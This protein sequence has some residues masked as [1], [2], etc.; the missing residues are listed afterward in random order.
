MAKQRRK[1]RIKLKS[2]EQ[3]LHISELGW[4][5]DGVATHDGKRVFVPFTL[6]G[7]TVRAM[8][9]GQR[10]KAIEVLEAAPQR[11]TAECSHFGNCG[12]CAVQ[13]L[14]ADD[15]RLWKRRVIEKAL[16]NR[17][18]DVPVDAL[19]DAHGDGRRRV[20]LHARFDGQRVQVGFMQAHT[21]HLVD[22]DRCPILAPQLE[23]ATA[24]ARDLAQP[25]AGTPKPLDIQ[26]TATETGLD[27]TVRGAGEVDLDIRMA[28][29]DCASTHDLARITVG[30]DIILE[31]RPPQLTFG[32]TKVTMP[33]GGFLQATKLGEETLAALVLDGVGNAKKVAD[34][35]CGIGPF[36]LR[37]AANAQVMAIDSDE[38]AIAA[39]NTAAHHTQG[40]KPITTDV[41]DLTHNP[42]HSSE[43]NKFDAVVFDPPRAGA[44]EQAWEIGQSRVKTV[45]GVSCNPATFAHDAS[46][47]LD[48]GYTLEKVTP[49]DQFRYAGHIEMV[50]IFRR[51]G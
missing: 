47:L 29:S 31:R 16:T 10:A 14:S 3:I 37:M 21:H 44:E 27:C 26:M 33:S 23:N 51:Q 17:D 18:M 45:V 34:L 19:I 1:K 49:V 20:T 42:M 41:R 11:V 4:H 43:L 24:I 15:Y 25:F 28:L 48:G 22:L 32:A 46:I 12:G 6:G 5:G 50:G 30:D 40:Q 2:S 9:T 35:Y 7:E 36:A 38:V 39:L 13:H 8:V